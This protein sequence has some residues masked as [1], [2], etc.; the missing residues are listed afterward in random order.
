MLDTGREVIG[1]R[2]H[3]GAYLGQVLSPQ[4]TGRVLK[5]DRFRLPDRAGRAH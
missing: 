2:T 4:G 3:R 5:L 1:F